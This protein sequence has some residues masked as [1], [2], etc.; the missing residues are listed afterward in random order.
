[1]KDR[2]PV[3]G[4]E[5]EVT[6]DK[7]YGK[8][9]LSCKYKKITEGMK[10]VKCPRCGKEWT[11]LTDAGICYDCRQKDYDDYYRAEAEAKQKEQEESKL[12]NRVKKS[13]IELSEP[14]EKDNDDDL[15]F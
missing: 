11:Q 14:K 6:I 12:V 9:C 15:P 10:F 4:I 5:K 7:R 3:C 13:F 8:I 1:M 2:C